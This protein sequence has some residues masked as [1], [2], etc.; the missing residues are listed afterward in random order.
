MLEIFQASIEKGVVPSRWSKTV[1][2]P[3]HK[4]GEQS[5]AENYQPVHLTSLVS[6][7]CEGCLRD[8]ILNHVLQSNMINPNQYG[9]LPSRR[10]T[11]QLLEMFNNWTQALEEG[12]SILA[13]LLDVE[14]AFESVLHAKLIDKLQQYNL[15]GQ[16]LSWI[17]SFLRNQIK[18]VRVGDNPEKVTRGVI[19]SSVIGS[20][21][22]ILSINKINRNIISTTKIYTD[23]T[24]L[25]RNFISSQDVATLQKTLTP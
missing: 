25:Y 24:K 1:V 5:K 13:A 9:F 19:Q 11:T 8:R 10:Y 14:K 22:F 4:K 17:E 15:P 16:I 21:L 23:D 12:H 7:L 2:V 20:F 6:K 3:T 18:K